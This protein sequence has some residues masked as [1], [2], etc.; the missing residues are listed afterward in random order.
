MSLTCNPQ[1]ET[2]STNTLAAVLCLVIDSNYN[3]NG[4]VLEVQQILCDKTGGTFG[5][6]FDTETA[7]I[8]HD[9]GAEEHAGSTTEAIDTSADLT[10]LTKL[11][12][13]IGNELEAFSSRLCRL[14]ASARYSSSAVGFEG[15]FE[16]CSCCRNSEVYLKPIH[17][18]CL[19]YF[20]WEEVNIN[21][22][23]SRRLMTAGGSATS[24]SIR[25]R[26]AKHSFQIQIQM[27]FASSL[28]SSLSFSGNKFYFSPVLC[29]GSIPRSCLDLDLKSYIR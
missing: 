7:F 23:V 4:E 3:G 15:Q 5:L 18:D 14:D 24:F 10:D 6:E 21:K 8:S 20:E 1:P 22:V 13:M 12:V 25:Y 29:A 2:Q 19:V 28:C 16:T 27:Q 26:L 17:W 11:R 9:D